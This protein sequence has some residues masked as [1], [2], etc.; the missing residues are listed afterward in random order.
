MRPPDGTLPGSEAPRTPLGVEARAA[1][2]TCVAFGSDN[3]GRVAGWLVAAFLAG[4]VAGWLVAAFLA[5]RVAGWLIAAFL[6]GRVAGAALLTGDAVLEDFFIR[7]VVHLAWG[8]LRSSRLSSPDLA[9][10]SVMVAS[11]RRAHPRDT[12]R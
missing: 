7:A 9:A 6:A 2:P 3:A 8:T 10:K 5:G 4:R 12:E 1:S 11:T